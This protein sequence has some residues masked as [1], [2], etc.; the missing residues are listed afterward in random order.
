MCVDYQALNKLTTPNRYPL[1]RIDDL[2]EKVK[3]WKW[4]TRLDLKNGYNFIRIRPGDEWKTAFKTKLR[5]YEYTVMPFGRINA[6]SSIQEMMDD[7]LRDL[8][9][10]TVWYIDDILIHTKGNNDDKEE[11]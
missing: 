11:D 3:G 4:F 9:T 5:L 7:I 1:P 10:H 8:D 6:P 2:Q